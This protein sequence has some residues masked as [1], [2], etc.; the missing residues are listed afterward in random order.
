MDTYSKE[1][2]QEK[3]RRGTFVKGVCVKMPESPHPRVALVA[4]MTLN[5][6][7]LVPA[8]SQMIQRHCTHHQSV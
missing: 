6:S 5:N 4:Q 1:G 8:T 7:A 3:M 2:A